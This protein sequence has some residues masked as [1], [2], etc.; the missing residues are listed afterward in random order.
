M[1]KRLCNF[2]KHNMCCCLNLSPRTDK[3]T[4][5]KFQNIN[6]RPLVLLN[7]NNESRGNLVQL[8][9]ECPSNP[10]GNYITDSML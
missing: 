6:Y 8:Y 10:I 1:F 3:I 7:T 9:V 4:S 2:L 5:D